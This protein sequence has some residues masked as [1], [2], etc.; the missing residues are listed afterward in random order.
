M[1]DTEPI[2]DLLQS[3]TDLVD[4]AASAPR[5]DVVR[6]RHTEDRKPI[7]PIVRASVLRRDRYRCVW[8]GS[9]YRL[10]MDHIIP[11]SARGAD[12]A[13][14]LRALCKSCNEARSNRLSLLD[15]DAQTMP[16]VWC[17]RCDSSDRLDDM[18][19][20]WCRRCG[21]RGFGYPA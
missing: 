16:A 2:G 10:E 20:V 14:N 13:D 12:T 5:A 19:E 3:V 11:W 18:V 17:T 9:R 7:N 6:T 1:N 4:E 21:S 8:C 15:L